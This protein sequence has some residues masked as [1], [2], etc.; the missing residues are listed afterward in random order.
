MRTEEQEY[1]MCNSYKIAIVQGII[2]YPNENWFISFSRKKLNFMPRAPFREEGVDR[3]R[4][5]RVTSRSH[6]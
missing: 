5:M 2:C 3:V 6:P 4:V 1:N